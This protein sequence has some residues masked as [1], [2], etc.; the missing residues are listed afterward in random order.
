MIN[1]QALVRDAMINVAASRTARDSVALNEGRPISVSSMAGNIDNRVIRV[2][3]QGVVKHYELDD[4]QQAMAVMMLGFNPKKRIED[5]F[6]GMKLGEYV[7][8]ALTGTS[9][10]LREAVTRTPPFQIKNI[11]RDSWQAATV[12]GGGPG[13]VIDAIA[14]ALDP[15]VQRRAEERGLSIGIDFVAEPGEYGNLMQKE[16]DKAD[17]DYE[18]EE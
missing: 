8:T 6:G 10:V 9:Q 17:L 13:L 1:T 11:L 5:L 15:D 14:N 4:A 18:D 16:L 7:S 3:E 2:M 12:V